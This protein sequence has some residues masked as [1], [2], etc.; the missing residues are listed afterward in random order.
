MHVFWKL[1]SRFA[2][3][4]DWSCFDLGIFASEWMGILDRARGEGLEAFSYTHR[5]DRSQK[6]KILSEHNDGVFLDWASADNVYIDNLAVGLHDRGKKII[7]NTG[8]GRHKRH[9]YGKADILLIESFL[10]TNSGDDGEWPVKY[11]KTSEEAD[12]GKLKSLKQ[13]GYNVIALTY[14]PVTEISFA[15]DC[16]GK[17]RDNGNDYFMYVQAPGWEKDNSGYRLFRRDELEPKLLK[18]MALMV[19]GRSSEGIIIL[20]PKKVSKSF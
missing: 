14:G 19:S 17:A 5:N 6:E 20:Y 11:S 7:V 12:I 8:W 18:R 10:G 3:Q 2:A 13:E 15:R 9:D 4:Q 16:F 1:K